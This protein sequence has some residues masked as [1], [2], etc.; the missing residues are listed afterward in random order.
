MEQPDWQQAWRRLRWRRRGAWQW[1]IFVVLTLLDG[2]VLTVLPVSGD[3]PDGLF[4]AILVAGFLNLFVVAVVA[5]LVALAVRRRRP[6]L[7]RIVARDYCGTALLVV[8]AVGLLIAGLAHR[9]SA[10]AAADERR[11]ILQSMQTYLHAEEPQL[12]GSLDRTDVLQLEP[13]YFR[14]C[15]P[16][17][18]GDRWLCVFVSTD[19]QP[20]GLRRDTNETPNGQLRFP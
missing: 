15:V 20:P 3:G 7:P 1:P 4:A 14:A 13:Q 11:A 10:A 18:R 6:D 5:P 8:A 16:R 19:Q 9:P 17:D 12:L 2:V